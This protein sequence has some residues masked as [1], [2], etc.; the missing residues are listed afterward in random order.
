MRS[1]GPAPAAPRSGRSWPASSRSRVVLP[2][3][4]TPTSPARAP[5]SSTK[6]RPSNSGAPSCALVRSVAFNMV[7]S[8]SGRTRGEGGV[9][10]AN[11]RQWEHHATARPA[12]VP[13]LI[14]QCGGLATPLSGR[15]KH[16]AMDVTFDEHEL[17]L[18]WV[19]AESM[20]RA[21][22]ALAA[23]G[24]VGIVDPVGAGAGLERVRALG[25]P[26]AVLQLLDRHNRDSAAVAARL[27]VPH[28]KV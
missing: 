24:R 18:S 27:G 22:H 16:E 25:E 17:G 8:L 4:L 15:A 13:G 20:M 19:A 12:Y 5:S 21:S 2:T 3:P 6:E 7:I 10:R 1:P 11:A 14:K 9:R 26:V 28:L 23:D